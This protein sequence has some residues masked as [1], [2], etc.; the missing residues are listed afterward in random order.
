MNEENYFPNINRE[1]TMYKV[2]IALGFTFATYKN[3]VRR[4]IAKTTFDRYIGSTSNNTAKFLMEKLFICVDHFYSKSA[5]IA[6]TYVL[7]KTGFDHVLSKVVEKDNTFT[8]EIAI[9][10]Y[11]NYNLLCIIRD[12][13][14]KEELDTKNFLYTKNKF[15]GIKHKLHEYDICVVRKAMVEHDLIYEYNF[16][17]DMIGLVVDYALKMNLIEGKIPNL[18]KYINDK[19]TFIKALSDRTGVD[20]DKLV[21][22]MTSIF[23]SSK[24]Y[25]TM[26][27][28]ED[29]TSFKENIRGIREEISYVRKFI[30][31]LNDV[32]KPKRMDTKQ[33]NLI[34]EYILGVYLE[35]I[36]SYTKDIGAK[37]FIYG[38]T[39]FTNEKLI[40]DVGKYT[41]DDFILTKHPKIVGDTDARQYDFG[42]TVNGGNFDKRYY[43]Y[44]YY[45][46]TTYEVFYVGCGKE[47]R[48][49]NHLTDIQSSIKPRIDKIKEC[50][51]T[52]IIEFI[53]KGMDRYTAFN[54]EKDSIEFY[55]RIDIGTGTLLNKTEGGAGVR[56][57]YNE[58][59]RKMG[60]K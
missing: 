26:Y 34:K 60:L 32:V 45:D 22:I 24:Q 1:D 6:K 18:M 37:I 4:M 8:T 9:E 47:Q 2:K 36:L 44:T 39:I 3:Y 12:T 38:T 40:M 19:D 50:G 27:F 35:N 41:I 20:A 25:L 17:G 48:C 31:E 59:S 33:T 13:K 5:G 57:S 30:S 7:N 14:I 42:S 49:Y 43:V 23:N 16:N 11:N 58:L 53:A 29:T 55:G 52:P 54:I 46:P 28:D 21:S 56:G 51:F 10:M 15:G